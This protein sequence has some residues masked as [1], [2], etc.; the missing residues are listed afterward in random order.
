MNSIR[1]RNGFDVSLALLPMAALVVAAG[2]LPAADFDEVSALT[3]PDS[4]MRIGIG[5]V[6]EDNF[7]YGQY[8]GLDEQGVYALAEVDLVNRDEQTGTWFIVS[9]HDLGLGRRDVQVEHNRQG[10][11]RYA[12]E[13]S[14]IPRVNPY[15]HST[16]FSGV[17]SASVTVN[18]EALRD[19]QLETERERVTLDVQK[20]FGSSVS[21]EVRARD[22]QKDGARM[23]GRG[24]PGAMEFLAEPIDQRIRALEAT[25]GYAGKKLHLAGGYYGTAFDN[26][27]SALQIAGGA[28]ALSG[29]TAPFSPLGL[30]PDNRSHQLYLTGGYHF[31]PSAAANFKLAYA[32]ATQDD[33]FILPTDTGRNNLGGR[34][35]TT[36]A[37]LGFTARP[38]SRLSLLANFRY[39]DRNDK[40]TVVDYFPVT[41]TTTATGENEPRDLKTLAGK[42]EASYYLPAGLRLTAGVEDEIKKRNSSSVRVVS[43][44]RETDEMSYRLELRRS[45]S[46]TVT[47][48]IAYIRSD[49]DGSGF[50]TTTLTTGLPGSNLIAPIHLADRERDKVRLLVDWTPV[51][52][53]SVQ[54]MVDYADDKYSGRTPLDLGVRSGRAEIY[55]IDASY[56]FSDDWQASAWISRNDNEIEQATCVGAV[57]G[58]GCP[59]LDTSP[60]WAAQSRN[61]GDAMG[62]GLQGKL[63]DRF[64]VG[65]DVQYSDI[66]DQ[67]LQRALTPTSVSVA[68]LPDINTRL[69]TATIFTRYTLP[70]NAMLRLDVTYDRF[71]TD[72]WTWSTF[73][74]TDGTRVTE[75]PEQD[76]MFV[77][78]SYLHRWQ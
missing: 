15:M 47:G 29:G 57:A 53:F 3:E 39:E 73:T 35:D 8:N 14:Q 74:Y 2:P 12:I 27:N 11:W 22:E 67:F 5:Y 66:E 59:A 43:H 75:D 20:W 40:T 71:R 65:V 62:L 64:D 7:R 36:A 44:R 48:A 32:R 6:D 4:E 46:E 63:T 33:E 78:L 31:T 37:Q 61:E 42:I 49:R 54:L 56:A 23:F 58:T 1:K 76:T 72:D 28:A 16:G 77:G 50:Q 30:A 10:D 68:P 26:D 21:F 52:P 38:F 45:V 41:V 25:L 19:V 60:V 18:G 69:A 9:G 24:T 13:Y 70:N 34:I 17:G 55:S 51:D